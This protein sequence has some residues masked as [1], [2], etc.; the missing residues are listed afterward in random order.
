MDSC[1]TGYG[2]GHNTGGNQYGYNGVP[3]DGAR[4]EG[5]P[6]DIGAPLLPTDGGGATYYVNNIAVVWGAGNVPIAFIYQTAVGGTTYDFIQETNKA[7]AS[8]GA[9][10][11]VNF[12]PVNITVSGQPG[13]Q[14][15]S[16]ITWFYPNQS[17]LPA[18]STAG[19]CW[20]NTGMEV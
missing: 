2:G 10:I 16:P 5:S 6:Y 18:G 7:P 4:C 8:F 20:P 14:A 1:A 19:S 11:G 13:F 15:V 17:S 3:T 9:S 12:G